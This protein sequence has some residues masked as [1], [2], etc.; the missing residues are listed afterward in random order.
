MTTYTLTQLLRFW[1]R[2]APDYEPLG[3]IIEVLNNNDLSPQ[4]K[5][6]HV[7]QILK[8]YNLEPLSEG[9]EIDFF[10]EPKVFDN[11]INPIQLFDIKFDNGKIDFWQNLN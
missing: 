5:Y 7:V 4:T 8:F 11:A 10:T 3:H 2:F 9:E 6:K 1:E